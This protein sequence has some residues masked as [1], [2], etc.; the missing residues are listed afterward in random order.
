MN[1]KSLKLFVFFRPQR[2]L[3]TSAFSSCANS[4]E[5]SEHF[6]IRCPWR[7]DRCG[8]GVRVE[9]EAQHCF[10]LPHKPLLS[11]TAGVSFETRTTLTVKIEYYVVL[12]YIR[13]GGHFNPAGSAFPLPYC[14]LSVEFGWLFIFF[15]V[16]F[17]LKDWLKIIQSMLESQMSC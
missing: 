6:L 10:F 16:F 11:L 14:W 13:H 5:Y 8:D 1:F 17:R 12:R 15:I 3:E 9:E 2:H 7:G 4:F